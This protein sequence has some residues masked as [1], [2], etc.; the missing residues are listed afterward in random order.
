LTKGVVQTFHG[1]ENVSANGDFTADETPGELTRVV[2][3]T[4]TAP[5]T[6]ATHVVLSFHITINQNGE[7]TANHFES[8]I[9]C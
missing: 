4:F 1:A 6:Q 8:N 3:Q 7:V 2:H 5:G 9:E